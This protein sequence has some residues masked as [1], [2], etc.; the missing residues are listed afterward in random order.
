MWCYTY[1]IQYKRKIKTNK[2]KQSPQKT[3]KLDNFKQ[4]LTKQQKIKRKQKREKNKIKQ[5]QILLS[6]FLNLNLILRI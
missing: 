3:I 6:R 5:K 2:K 1:N 4:M